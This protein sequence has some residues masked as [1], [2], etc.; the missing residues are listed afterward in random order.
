MSK[1]RI[2]CT[3]NLSEKKKRG[4]K[5]RADDDSLVSMAD[6]RADDSFVSIAD[7]MLMMTHLSVWLIA[8]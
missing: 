5:T 7:G 1:N 6:G 2:R 3:R 4:E 8:C